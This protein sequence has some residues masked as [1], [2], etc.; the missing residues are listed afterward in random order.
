MP[1]S[2]LGHYVRFDEAN[3]DSQEYCDTGISRRAIGNLD[4]LADQYAQQRVNWVSH[5]SLYLTQDAASITDDVYYPMWTSTPFDLHVREDL[6]SYRCFVRLR[7]QSD[8][9]VQSAVFRAILAPEGD[10]E[11]DLFTA[12]V[13]VFTTATITSAT[14]AWVSGGSLIYLDRDHVRR[15]TRTVSTVDSVGGTPV[16]ATWLRARLHVWGARSNSQAE[17]R[18]GGVHL[19]EYYHP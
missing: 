7:V 13:N 11:A 12:G 18:L 19:R 17:P 10:A 4:H 8:D 5:S 1:S 2:E 14:F 3:V 9:A 6:E 16:T 15:A